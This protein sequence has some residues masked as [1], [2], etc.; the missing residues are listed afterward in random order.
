MDWLGAVVAM[1]NLLSYSFV[2]RP[3]P[4]VVLILVAATSNLAP[5]HAETILKITDG[6]TIKVS[7]GK[8]VRL[9]QIDTPEPMSS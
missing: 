6:D 4:I 8:D 1:R 7:T 3:N 9:L 5:A 2:M